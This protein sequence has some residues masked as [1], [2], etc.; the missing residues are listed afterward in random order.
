M[1]T[2]PTTIAEYLRQLRAELRDA[3]PA[4]LQDAL[5]DA[6]EY[7]RSALAEQPER[8]E[9]EVLAE[10]ASS[11][12]APSEVADI[13]RNTE[14]TVT[15]ALRPPRPAPQA[16]A[17]KAFFGVASDPRAYA[18]LFYMLLSLATGVFYFGWTMAGLSLSVGLS[19]LIIG[20]PFVIL[21]F[22]SVRLLSLVEGRLVEV[23]L[24]ERMPRRPPYTDRKQPLMARIGAMF[25]DPRTWSTLLYLL[26]ML[27]LGIVYFVSAVTGLSLGTGL[28][29]GGF[30]HLFSAM[31][32]VMVDD[33]HFTLPRVFAPFVIVLGV[34]LLFLTLHLARGVARLHGAL[35][36]H[37]LVKVG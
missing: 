25:S 33:L 24:G 14:V 11:Y 4:L 29:V 10:I 34:V 1:S 37:L 18:G 2:L 7:L 17:L 35:A 16:N 8:P 12:G 27:P 31:G 15:R 21:F 5:Y 23:M 26:L 6:E 20:I 9:A 36:K 30:V 28:V 13:Y 19:I 22:G 32:V 3:D